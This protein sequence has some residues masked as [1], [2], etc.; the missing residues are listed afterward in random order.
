MNNLFCNYLKKNLVSRNNNAN[1]KRADSN[2]KGISMS[3][4]LI[5]GE[6]NLPKIFMMIALSLIVLLMLTSKASA[7]GV[8]PGRTTLNFEPGL[9]KDIGLTVI[10]TEKKA[11]TVVMYVRGE[12]KDYVKL[13]QQSAVFAEGEETKSFTYSVNLPASIDKPGVHKT[14]IVVLEVSKES[15]IKTE[16]GEEVI[17]LDSPSIGARLAV[18]S[19][20]YVYVLHPGKYL[21]AGL[22][23]VAHDGKVRFLV[24]ITSQGKLGIGSARASI[25]IYT[26][27][28]E[29]VATIETNSL[30]IE[31]QE[32][33]ELFAEW[34]Y[35]SAGINPGRYRAVATIT[36]DGQTAYSEREFEVGSKNVEVESISVNNFALGEIAK[37]SILVNN[38]W[39]SPLKDVIVQMMVYNE[40]GEVMADFASQSYEIPALS[41]AEVVS[42]WDT[43]GVKEGTYKGKL[44]LKYE[45][46]VTERPIEIIVSDNNIEVTGF[47]G[48]AI[49]PKKSFFSLQNVLIGIVVLLIVI[50]AT[51]FFLFLRK[52]RRQGVA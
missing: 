37:F 19:Q 23:A 7:I 42:Y 36:Y 22:D 14:E 51:W 38:Q 15:K 5:G 8:S 39:A 6:C 43:V 34:D 52:K 45:D 21:D 35:E 40:N 47:T 1:N 41:K 12:L 17:V 50:N 30:S 33:K 20:L 4:N 49:F 31:S 48:K 25:D 2:S 9:A 28:N 13:S 11:M 44:I 10:N 32:R 27:L 3:V 29:K 46:R 16:T 18:I 26:S 24:P